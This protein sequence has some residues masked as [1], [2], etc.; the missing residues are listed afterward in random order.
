MPKVIVCKYLL[1]EYLSLRV[2]SQL[3]Y[4][5]D[6]Q[7]LEDYDAAKSLELEKF[8]AEQSQENQLL[9]EQI[10]KL[11]EDKKTLEERNKS[12]QEKNKSISKNHKGE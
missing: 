12:L 11:A 4:S 3:I 8:K 5:I 2:A 9:K 10:A 1:V 7:E 6:L